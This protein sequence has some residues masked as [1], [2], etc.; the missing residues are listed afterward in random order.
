MSDTAGF[1]VAEVPPSP[2]VLTIDLS[3]NSLPDPS[4]HDFLARRNRTEYDAVLETL[5]L[6][7]KGENHAPLDAFENCRRFAFFTRHKDTG[8]VKV[9]SSCCHNRWCPPCATAKA[10]VFS[11]R[12]EEWLTGRKRPRQLELTLRSTGLPLREQTD[13]LYRCWR[14]LR[15]DPLFKKVFLAGVWFFQI[16]YNAET[17]LFHPHLHCLFVGSYAKQSA[18]SEKWSEITNGSTYV[19]I[20][21][22]KDV[23]TSA[24]YVSRYVARP[25]LLSDLPEDRRL[26]LV[27]AMYHRRT[28]GTFGRDG[29]R[30]D[31]TIPKQD[32]TPYIRICSWSELRDLI[33]T[34][35]IHQVIYK[36]WLTGKPLPEPAILLLSRSSEE[37]PEL[38]PTG[39]PAVF[40]G[41]LAGF[42]A[43]FRGDFSD[44]VRALR[45]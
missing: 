22:V 21:S 1:D 26:E 38:L 15:L 2:S 14:L 31:L 5:K 36:C 3:V 7:Y 4:Y 37:K 25:M 35:K 41:I 43:D 20:Q 33:A 24:K 45:A 30:P 40:G 18:I 34:S 32:L 39:P 23:S 19:F 44:N 6:F 17:G 27:D 9:L 13:E 11:G 29:L 16:T 8:E 12:I 42:S 10:S 28:A